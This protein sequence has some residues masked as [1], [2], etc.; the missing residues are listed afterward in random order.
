MKEN[1]K[2]RKGAASFYIVA[3]STLI[4]MIVAASFAAVIVSEVTRTS[5]DDLSQSA[6]DSALA[7][8]EDA[9]L[10]YYSYENCRRSDGTMP[11][12]AAS[13]D[14]T[15]GITC[16]ELVWYMEH[17][18][19][20]MVGN[21]LDR[22]K[23]DV[24]AIEEVN[25]NG[26]GDGNSSSN[27]MQQYYTCVEIKDSLKDYRGT[28]SASNM[29]KT[30]RAKF[31]GDDVADKIEKVKISWYADTDY[32]GNLT[33]DGYTNMSGNNV[34]F[35]TLTNKKAATPPTIFLAMVQTG[36]TFDINS[37]DVT[38]QNNQTDR[39]MI[40]LVPT[41][42]ANAAKTGVPGNHNG[43]K[44]ENHVNKIG[45]GALSK[46]ND[47]TAQNLPYTVYCGEASDNEFACSA[48]IDLP[49]PIGG[50]RNSDTFMFVVGLPY[51]K[52]SKS[53]QVTFALEF[54]CA[55]SAT[56]CGKQSAVSE[57]ETGNP[58]QANLKGVQIQ[59][60]STGRANDLFRRVETRLEDSNGFSL[61]IMGPLELLGDSGGNALEKDYDEVRCEYNFG[62]PTCND[63]GSPR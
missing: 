1:K 30:M 24:V 31:D 57:G 55:D 25:V 61:S 13:A 37:F 45:A 19:C 29:I 23:D 36:L 53:S 38:Q 22:T 59:V 17:P 35:P 58:T 28:L 14:N 41:N 52:A 34:V 18:D 62:G 49:K 4:L 43:T 56:S 42:N 51:G 16:A 47:K 33:S 32:E 50:V 48:L 11:A 8:V 46:S 63:D 10:A 54:F 12:A 7:G 3:F 9:K 6:Y 27:N 44:Y 39:G 60:D 20:N 26:S 5:N 40:Y 21:M 15:D 2:F